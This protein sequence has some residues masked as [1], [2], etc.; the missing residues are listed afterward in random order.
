MIG[1]H[2]ACSWRH[3][4]PATNKKLKTN[5][6]QLF[7]VVG[8]VS[9]PCFVGRGCRNHLESF[10]WCNTSWVAAVR[11]GA[12][13]GMKKCSDKKMR[14]RREFA[15]FFFCSCP[16]CPPVSL[17]H[18]ALTHQRTLLSQVGSSPAAPARRSPNAFRCR[19]RSQWARQ[20]AQAACWRASLQRASGG[21]RRPWCPLP[22][23]SPSQPT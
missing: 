21:F 17:L 10:G 15:H 3:I 20:G 22:G 9:D 12:P 5:H 23:P 18:Q 7:L 1:T 13:R 19:R 11:S 2:F 14:N 16:V 4:S 8:Q 6:M